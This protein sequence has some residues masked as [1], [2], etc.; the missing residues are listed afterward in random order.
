MRPSASGRSWREPHRVTAVVPQ[1]AL[2]ACTNHVSRRI[3]TPCSPSQWKG[4][5]QPTAPRF[6]ICPPG[7]PLKLPQAWWNKFRDEVGGKSA[8]HGDPGVRLIEATEGGLDY[9]TTAAASFRAHADGQWRI[10]PHTFTRLAAT[11]CL[12]TSGLPEPYAASYIKLNPAD[13]ARSWAS[14]PGRA[15]PLATMAIR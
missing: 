15:S 10:A 8:V 9:F 1:C 3:K 12:S 6:E 4:N 14:M 2:P 7:A 11:N 5:N 13:A